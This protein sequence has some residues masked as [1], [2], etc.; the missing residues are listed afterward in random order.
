[1]REGKTLQA[2]R[3]QSCP[4]YIRKVEDEKQGRIPDQMNSSLR[5]PQGFEEALHI[6][7]PHFTKYM[8]MFVTLV[9]PL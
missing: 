6:Q 7:R 4:Y 9:L 3:L 1:M 2:K 8:E 5:N